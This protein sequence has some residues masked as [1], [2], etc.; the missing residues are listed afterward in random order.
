MAARAFAAGD[1]RV[2]DL[3]AALEFFHFLRPWWLALAPLAL[4]PWWRVR[5]QAT[6]R[7]DP[8]I[9]LAPHLAAAL[10]VG[11]AKRRRLLPID[12]VMA[13]VVVIAFAAAGPTW[14]RIP[15][16]LLAQTAPL[17][18]ALEASETMLESDVSPSRLERAKHKILDLIGVRAGARTALIAYSGSAHRVVPLTE[19][20]EVIKP[21]LEGL[22]PKVM[23]AR[24]QNA[25][26]AL[27][28][29]RETLAPEKVPGAILFVLDDLDRAD[30]PAFERHAAEDGPRIVFLSIGGSSAVIDDLDRVPGATVVSVTPDGSD[31]AEIESRVAS[32]YREALARDERQRW[33][34]RGWMLAWPAALLVLIW[35]RRGWTMRWGA[36]LVAMLSGTL[37]GQVRADGIADWLLTPDQQG[38]LAYDDREFAEAGVLFEDPM[39][40]GYALYRAGKYSEAAKV[41][42]R[43]P[44]ADSAFAQGV[45]HV[46]GREYHDG[47]AAFEKALQRNPGN[48]I[49][50]RNLA[51]AH[52]VLAYVE[53]VREQSDT[54]EGSEGADDVVFDKEAGRGVKASISERDQMKIQTAEQW[55]RTVDTRTA[56]F[57][58]LRFALEAAK[59]EK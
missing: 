30:W 29:A 37:S 55:M 36:L 10:T 13:I 46:K 35:F 8:P 33:D 31:V 54:R 11:A 25:T 26:A 52:A 28:L 7:L 17:A 45:A 32:A 43:M 56:D 23:P 2:T 19:D 21:F 48:Q 6:A 1:V 53:R 41:F 20:P 12:G 24:G 4:V 39:W 18:I 47:I 59:S 16:P 51:I 42:A 49:I 40:K 22:S 57:L 44:T 9:G 34:D 50:A 27:A 58:R 14:S 5:R 3:V 38:R 15:N